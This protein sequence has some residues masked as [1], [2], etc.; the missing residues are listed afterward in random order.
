MICMA[1]FFAW[2][3]SG[4]FSLMVDMLALLSISRPT[5]FELAASYPKENTGGKKGRAS[6]IARKHTAKQR[7]ARRSHFFNLI[8]LIVLF[9]SRLKNA[10]VEKATFLGRRKLIRCIMTGIETAAN[11]HKRNGLRKLIYTYLDNNLYISLNKLILA[12]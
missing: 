3:I 4:P 2:S 7:R 1:A 5:F 10:R 9:S 8:F 11:P 12:A 6:A